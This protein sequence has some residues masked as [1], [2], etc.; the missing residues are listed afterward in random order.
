MNQKNCFILCLFIVPCL[1]FGQTEGR[2]V[3]VGFG[4]DGISYVGDLSDPNQRIHRIYPGANL[5]IQLEGPKR[6]KIQLNGGFGKFSEQ[7][8][9]VRPSSSPGVTVNTFVETSFYYGDLRLKYRFPISDRFHPFL[10]AGAG[11]LS[12]TPRD[13]EGRFLNDAS[14]TREPDENYSTIVPQIPVGAGVQARIN[15]AVSLSLEYLFRYTPTDYLDNIGRLGTRAGHDFLHGLQLSMYITLNA[16]PPATQPQPYY[17][18]QVVD[19]A[20][21]PLDTMAEKV[22]VME[23]AVEEMLAEE[24][25]TRDSAPIE[26]ESSAEPKTP[27]EAPAPAEEPPSKL[28]EDATDWAAKE[29]EAIEAEEYITHKVKKNDSLASIAQQYHVSIEGLMQVNYLSSQTI[30]KGQK[31]R[32]PKVE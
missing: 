10:T 9:D 7:Y 30:L 28:G 22:A 15:P 24:E 13:Q 5:S 31:I 20:E 27:L 26:T 3:K 25:P 19:T 4:L 11:V 16:P 8:D 21:A 17:N 6:L 18:A 1:L 2:Q 14:F 32:V 12:F 29:K 23:E